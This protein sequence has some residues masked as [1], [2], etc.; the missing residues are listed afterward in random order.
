MT[1]RTASCVFEGIT[2]PFNLP[3]LITGGPGS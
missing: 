2:D 1:W 3:G